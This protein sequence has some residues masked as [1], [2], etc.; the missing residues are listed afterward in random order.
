MILIRKQRL[1]GHIQPHKYYRKFGSQHLIAR[2]HVQTDVG[3]HHYLHHI[4]NISRSGQR[5]S[6]N[7]NRTHL[8]RNRRIFPKHS[9]NIRHRAACDPIQFFAVCLN[10]LNNKI[11]GILRLRVS[12]VFGGAGRK[13]AADP[14]HAVKLAAAAE[15]DMFPAERRLTSH[16]YRNLRLSA[17]PKDF[18]CV[19][20]NV[21]HITHAVG[22]G[23]THH[24]AL[25]L[26]RQ[27][28][29]RQSVVHA[30]IT[31]V[32]NLFAHVKSPTFCLFLS[33]AALHLQ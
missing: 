20:E 32:Q 8:F 24:L 23:N 25:F 19:P 13:Y 33:Y 30:G 22:A 18:L 6:H 10:H 4:P 11:R 14:G 28:S 29:K 7:V 16:N 27:I 31:A 2:L 21:T 26:G 15:I 17:E 3:F 5:T 1:A 9:R 12:P